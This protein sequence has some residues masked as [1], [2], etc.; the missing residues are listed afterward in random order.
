M[1]RTDQ[2]E[3]TGAARLLVRYDGPDGPA[4]GLW[5]P[6]GIKA[7]A[8][9]LAELLRLPADEFVGRARAAELNRMAAL[10]HSGTL[11][12]PIDG[13]TELWASGVT[14]E[15]S[16]EARMTESETS[17]TVYEQVYEADR[18]ELFFKSVGWRTR[19]TG[20]EI[21]VRADSE[22][23]VP[24]PELAVLINSGGEIVGAAVCNDMS[25]RSIEGENPL[26]LPQAKIYRGSTALGPGVAVLGA[27]EL[28]NLAISLTIVRD[29]AVAWSGATSTSRLHRTITDLVTWLYAELDFPDGAWLSTG[30]GLVPDLPFALAVGDVV[31]IAIDRVG[32]LINTVTD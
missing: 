20:D 22:I 16:R 2:I 24:E 10:P 9:T 31:T 19:T 23:N 6:A 26:Y 3:P 15:I 8:P 12:A 25:S 29:G 30:T 27:D 7:I 1:I 14:Y 18:P 21:R 32:T 28:A 17:A 13:R 11:L 4:V 5:Q